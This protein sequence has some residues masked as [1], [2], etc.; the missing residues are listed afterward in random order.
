MAF[1]EHVVA[2]LTTAGIISAARNRGSV[3]ML[4]AS[5]AKHYVIHEHNRERHPHPLSRC[6]VGDCNALIDLQTSLAAE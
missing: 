4:F 1:V 6:T 5:K 2:G 3:V